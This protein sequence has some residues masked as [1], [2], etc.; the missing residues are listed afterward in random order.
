MNMMV[1]DDDVC[2]DENYHDHD[3]SDVCIDHVL[4]WMMN[5]KMNVRVEM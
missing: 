2:S 4:V 3:D 5:V 1:V